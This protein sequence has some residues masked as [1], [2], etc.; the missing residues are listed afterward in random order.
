MSCDFAG[1]YCCT[2]RLGH[3]R[4]EFLY[5]NSIL[6]TNTVDGISGLRKTLTRIFA[7]TPSIHAVLESRLPA[8]HPKTPEDFK[9]PDP[10][11]MRNPSAN[12]EEPSDN[13]KLSGKTDSNYNGLKGRLVE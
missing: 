11:S 1:G 6:Q 10:K 13:L 9:R 8:S 12:D 4:Q 2:L 7:S 5:P 3:L